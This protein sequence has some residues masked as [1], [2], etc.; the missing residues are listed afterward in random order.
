MVLIF[1]ITVFTLNYGIIKTFKQY[2]G[3][4]MKEDAIKI[5]LDELPD[6]F[7][8]E[9]SDFVEFLFR[10]HKKRA[11]KKKFSFNWE[12]GLSELKD[13]YSSVELQHKALEWR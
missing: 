5:K 3:K 1:F 2:G 13:K 11:E 6:D 7:K 4:A 9:V 8:K 10:K 12:G